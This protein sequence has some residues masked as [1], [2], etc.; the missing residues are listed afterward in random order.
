MAEMTNVCEDPNQTDFELIEDELEKQSY[1]SE[2]NQGDIED[3][4]T[5]ELNM[6]KGD[7]K[8]EIFKKKDNPDQYF[9]RWTNVEHQAFVKV[10]K[11]F[12]LKWSYLEAAIKTRN[13]I[14]IRS[15]AQ[16]YLKSLRKK[17]ELER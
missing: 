16:K 14:Q 1:N 5:D 13:R 15:H 17:V 11:K 3:S 9:G 8:P 4:D 7:L 10:Y 2:Q 6:K 12:G